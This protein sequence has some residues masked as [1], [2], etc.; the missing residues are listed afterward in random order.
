MNIIFL[1]HPTFEG[2]QSMPRFAKMLSNGMRAR[3]HAVDIWS[4][5]PYFHKLSNNAS[6]Q[7]WLGYLDQYLL[8]PKQIRQQSSQL[9]DDTLFVFTDQAL[10]MWVPTLADR[11]HVIHCHDFLALR[12][13]LNEI[14]E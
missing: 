1:A 9:P 3:G 4:P 6:I 2:H 13:A 8:F 14:P 5:R 11:N 12:S 10:G 7:K